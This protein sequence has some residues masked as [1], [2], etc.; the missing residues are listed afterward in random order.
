[1]PTTPPT[2]GN[3]VLDAALAQIAADVDIEA[4]ASTFITTTVPQLITA[5]VNKA[6]AGGATAAQLAALTTLSATLAANGSA[7][8]AAIVAQT[9]AAATAALA[10]AVKPKP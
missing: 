3:P 10:Q 6:L 9:P 8:A 5:A 4:S 2:T 7:V 1:M